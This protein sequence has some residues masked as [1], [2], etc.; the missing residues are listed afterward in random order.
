VP[1]FARVARLFGLATLLSTFFFSSLAQPLAAREASTAEQ[2]AQSAVAG[3]TGAAAG[4]VVVEIVARQG[5]WAYGTGAVPAGDGHDAP[6]VFIFLAHK[7]GAG[8]VAE[9][10]FTPGFNALL[11]RAPGSFPTPDIRAT[12]DGVRIAGDGSSDLAFPW[13]VGQA[14]RFNGPHANGGSAILGAIDFYPSP[15]ATN[16]PVLAMRGGVVYRPC[17]NMVM[18][19]HGDGWSSY[20]YHLTNIAVAQGQYVSRGQLLG[21]TSDQVACGGWAS[22]P[23][24]HIYLRYENREVAIDGV[25]IG[26]W[27]VE[28]GSKQYDGCLVRGDEKHCAQWFSSVPNDGVSG[29]WSGGSDG[30][31]P[32]GPVMASV[33]PTRATVNSSVSYTLNG[34]PANANVQITWRR[35]TGSTID[36]GTTRTDS[37]GAVTGA[38]RVPATPG[39]PNQQ[40]TFSSGSVSK[41]VLFEVAPRIKVNTSPGVRGQTVDVSLRGYARQEQ[42][43]IRWKKP[44]GTWIDVANLTTSNT[45]SANVDVTVPLWAADGNNS[46]RGDGSVFRQQTNAV[47]IEGGTFRAAS[48]AV[49]ASWTPTA[50]ATPATIT[51]DRSALPVADPLPIVNAV[52]HTGA[53]P[54][55]AVFDNDPA[56][57]WQS[58]P[59]WGTATLTIDLGQ[60]ITMSAVAWLTMQDGCGT[61]E[62][63]ESSLDG[64]NWVILNQTSPV[65]P[66][67]PGVWQTLAAAQDARFLRWVVITTPDQP[68]LGCLAEVAVWGTPAPTLEPTY[69]ATTEPQEP[70]ATAPAMET[71]SPAPTETA[72]SEPAP[73]EVVVEATEVP[74]Q[75][76][77][78]TAQPEA[79][80][81]SSGT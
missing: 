2:A 1:H 43:R 47:Y 17:A 22:G 37:G 60:P 9:I 57:V 32:S 24:V 18:I 44:D 11:A 58:D 8:W 42:V 73:T 61:I 54:I 48:V 20:Y 14:W 71:E 49:T 30:G 78:T 25:D 3:F 65:A 34:F 68:N 4:S 79:T 69:P 29:S 38:F 62:R 52:D 5:A 21:G 50:T 36:M 77:D 16:A 64:E 41:T 7:S 81:E 19:D 55:S 63:V 15:T 74:E 39:G 80:G 26:G 51:I 31:D 70:N 75:P 67:Q 40:I 59:A 23:H 35:L 13:A 66:G 10:R 12:L 28:N 76:T 27:T 53:Q 56:T 72:T 6:D 46:V 33:S 45:G